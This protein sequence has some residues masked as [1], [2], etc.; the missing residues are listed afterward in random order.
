MWG[1]KAVGQSFCVCISRDGYLRNQHR[2]LY[3]SKCLCIGGGVGKAVSG[4]SAYAYHVPGIYAIDAE[5][6]IPLFRLPNDIVAENEDP[7]LSFV[8]SGASIWKAE[9]A[10]ELDVVPTSLRVTHGIHMKWIEK[11]LVLKAVQ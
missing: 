3:T 4:C 7:F 2:T 6:F 11:L 9:L 10:D 8:P 5:H 1:G